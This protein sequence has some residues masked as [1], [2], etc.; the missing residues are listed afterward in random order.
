MVTIT[1]TV[2]QEQA[3]ELRD[4]LAYMGRAYYMP[5]KSQDVFATAVEKAL[6]KYQ[7]THAVPKVSA[8]EFGT[9]HE[10]H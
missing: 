3:E 9:W 5:H 7:E 10:V 8:E 4:A 6:N 2:T 1:L